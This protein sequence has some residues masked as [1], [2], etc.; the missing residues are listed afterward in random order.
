MAFRGNTSNVP[1]KYFQQGNCKWGNS[2]KYAHVYANGAGSKQDQASGMTEVELYKS[3]ISPSSFAKIQKN[4]L[5]DLKESEVIQK[6]PLA[7]A[8]S[9]GLPCGVNLI[10][11]R[12]LSPEELR[13]KYY[14]ARQKGTLGQ[15][16][17]EVAARE[18]DMEKCFQHIRGHPDWAAR[19]L[20][21]GTK[22]LRETGQ[23]TIKSG[24]ID[25][26]VDL[27]GQQSGFGAPAASTFGTNPF[28]QGRSAFGG[29]N[30]FGSG[31]TGAFGQAQAQ[32]SGGAFGQGQA[33]GSS[34]AFGFGGA[35]KTNTVN[36]FGSSN[37][38]TQPAGGVFGKPAFSGI[39]ANP[40]SGTAP[41]NN[42]FGGGAA[43]GQA[44]GT[45]SVF[46]QAQF[47]AG[48]AAGSTTS[49]FGKPTFG[50][51]S[52]GQPSF[53]SQTGSSAFNSNKPPAA[54]ASTN[55]PFASL[56][57]N[58]NNTN[59]SPFGSLQSKPPGG[60]T[61]SPFGSLQNNQPAAGSPFAGLQ[62]GNSATT[63]TSTGAFSQ[64]GGG[65]P[66]PFAGMNSTNATTTQGTGQFGFNKP[67]ATFGSTTASTGNTTSPFG[68]AN[69]G[70]TN[71][72]GSGFNSN[73]ADSTPSRGGAGGHRFVQGLPEE[74]QLN[75]DDLD[76][77]TL[78][79]FQASSFILGKVPDIPPPL[80]L[81]L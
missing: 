63:N 9:Y 77:Q 27:T 25:F 17:A 11:D 40:A 12:D 74:A 70:S 68:Q 49:A 26:P 53:G 71:V 35:A 81:I 33:Q 38:T 67:T 47:G 56:Q 42:V 80:A 61:A 21:K 55:S 52:F 75:P 48:P 65:N 36:A 73:P 64:M 79:Q 24:F 3:F 29:S 43:T 57:N 10:N 4:I 18:K 32:G 28:T 5:T 51:S 30:A 45:G 50:G 20:Q 76:K 1:C 59:Q 22:E 7:S 66:S 37:P 23:T 78:D 39:S 62:N 8:Y 41:T 6:R 16:E 72:F 69:G 19:Y 15:Y 54:G 46:G 34:G 58:N 44:M 60:P 2:C 14:E 31:A 13:F